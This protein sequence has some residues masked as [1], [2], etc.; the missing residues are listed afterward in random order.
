M[1]GWAL[2]TDAAIWTLIG[3]SLVVFGWFLVEVVR[4]ARRT[5]NHDDEPPAGPSQ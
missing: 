5:R 1:S 2:A 4:L 3:G